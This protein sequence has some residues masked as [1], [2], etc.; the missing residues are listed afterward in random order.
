MSKQKY[1]EK[2]IELLDKY[3]PKGEKFS[4]RG[5][6]MVILSMAFLEGSIKE[7]DFYTCKNC[8]KTCAYTKSNKKNFPYCSKC[9]N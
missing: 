3:F 2:A 5:E 1:P 6:A 8:S 7:G 9:K 4:R